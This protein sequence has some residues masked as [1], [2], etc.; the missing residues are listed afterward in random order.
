[1]TIT[2]STAVIFV[3]RSRLADVLWAN[4]E[5]FSDFYSCEHLSVLVHVRSRFLHGS[6]GLIFLLVEALYRGL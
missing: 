4:R 6:Y 2:V 1:M 3:L 5:A